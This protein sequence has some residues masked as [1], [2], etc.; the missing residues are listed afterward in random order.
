MAKY[1]P[2]VSCF[3]FV[4]KVLLE[5]GLGIKAGLYRGRL[6]PIFKILMFLF[7]VDFVAFRLVFRKVALKY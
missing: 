2:Q 6:G 1:G 4:N 5:V 3:A 7:I